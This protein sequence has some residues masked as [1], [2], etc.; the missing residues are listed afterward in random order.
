M[1][2]R[3]P[4]S[5]R[6]TGSSISAIHGR[7]QRGLTSSASR[8]AGPSWKTSSPAV[9]DLD[10]ELDDYDALDDF[11]SN[12]II[13]FSGGE[14]LGSPEAGPSRLSRSPRSSS[15]DPFNFFPAR[16]G[17]STTTQSQAEAP[18]LKIPK[19]S[20]TIPSGI[21]TPNAGSAA[22]SPRPSEHFDPPPLFSKS[23]ETAL[24]TSTI[25]SSGAKLTTGLLLPGNVTV[26]GVDDGGAEGKP[27]QIDGVH[28]VDDSSQRGV[29][30]YFVE[31]QTEEEAFLAS[32]NSAKICQN[33]HRPGHRAGECPHVIV[34]DADAPRVWSCLLISV[35]IMWGRR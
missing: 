25:S 10:D 12:D 13:A 21:D 8:R 20:S 24:D 7:K 6:A 14:D 18:G 34:S 26:E 31:K 15:V 28:F 19:D 32:A 29:Q 23:L 16:S 33:C 4:G 3:P 2:E 9:D 35:R 22:A 11:D 30:R 5:K 27:A 1:G 17:L